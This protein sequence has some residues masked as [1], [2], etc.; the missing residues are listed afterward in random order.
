MLYFKSEDIVVY[1][2]L[3]TKY[4]IIKPFIDPEEP[5]WLATPAEIELYKK[6]QNKKLGNEKL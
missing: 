2:G 5:V 6:S 3:I 1:E 4:S